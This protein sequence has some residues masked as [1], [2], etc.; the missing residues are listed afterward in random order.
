VYE[1][2]TAFEI[3]QSITLFSKP[4]TDVTRDGVA[5]S[6]PGSGV[7][8]VSERTNTWVRRLEQAGKRVARKGLALGVRTRRQL[9]GVEAGGMRAENIVWIFGSARTGSTWLSRIMGELKGQTVWREPLVGA[10]FGNLYYERAKHLIGKTG[11]HYILGDGYRESWLEGIRT[12]V[13]KE[14]IGR[15]PEAAGPS[16]YLIIKEP[17]GSA[18]APLLSEAIPESRMIL[19]VRDPR[20]VAASSMDAKRKGSWQY[21]NRKRGEQKEESL[22]DTDPNAFVKNRAR[23]YL[24]AIGY[25]K[26]AYEAHKGPKI[27]VLYEELR[28]D[29]L[30]TMKHIYS[31]LGIPVDEG[32]LSRAVKQHSWESIP[33]EE[34][35]EGKVFR[36]ATPGGWR[37][38][39]TPEQIV[40]V[41]RITG[42]LLDEFYPE[43]KSERSVSQ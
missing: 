13:L 18:G 11:K 24:K 26:Q 15:F 34:K 21:E 42:S 28:A 30:G 31:T 37:E 16:N 10:L 8:K 22:A 4:E 20:D 3:A 27:L 41:E 12:F 1:N 25:T 39:L 2:R 43:W 19:L 33:E 6:A 40:A 5:T 35:G 29:A 23:S 7:S 9:G 36:K 14:A 38:D 32:E 17:N